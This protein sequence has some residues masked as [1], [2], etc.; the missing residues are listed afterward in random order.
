MKKNVVV[1]IYVDIMFLCESTSCIKCGGFKY[2]SVA[3]FLSW[4]QISVSTKV[5]TA[6]LC[7]IFLLVVLDYLP[8]LSSQ[9]LTINKLSLSHKAAYM[10]TNSA[11]ND[12]PNNT[13]NVIKYTLFWLAKKNKN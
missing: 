1:F 9:L 11:D 7:P 10:M 13:R 12:H 3:E 6:N 4:K 5:S 8:P 2:V